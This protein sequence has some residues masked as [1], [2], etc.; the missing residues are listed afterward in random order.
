MRRKTAKP[1]INAKTQPRKG[2]ML[3]DMGSDIRIISWGIEW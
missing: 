3:T 2:V 1:D